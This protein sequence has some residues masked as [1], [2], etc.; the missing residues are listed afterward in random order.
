MEFKMFDSS[1]IGLSFSFHI[2]AH[3]NIHGGFFILEFVPTSALKYR[4][5]DE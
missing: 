2:L 5:P 4:I 3:L 1:F